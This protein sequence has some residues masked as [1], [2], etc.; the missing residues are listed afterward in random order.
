MRAARDIPL[1]VDTT[2]LYSRDENLWHISHEGGPLED[3]TNE[4][5]EAMFQWTVSAE[6]APDEAEFVEI[7]FAKGT[8][9]ALDGEPLDAVT[10]LQRLNALGSRHG[11]G[12]ADVIEDRLVGMKSRGVYETPGGTILYGALARARGT[13]PRPPLARAQ[14]SARAALRGP[15]LRGPL[16]DARARSA[17]RDG[18]RAAPGRDRVREDEALQGQ[19]V[20]RFTDER[21]LALSGGPGHLRVRAR[22][23]TMRMRPGS[24]SCSG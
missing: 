5:E 1:N 18:E 15:G 12:R 9:V 4:P 17:R 13:D 20:G 23:T 21:A 14:G 22:A 2:K 11:V 6:A 10:L 8:P 24:S 3:P 19:H 7:R 16:V